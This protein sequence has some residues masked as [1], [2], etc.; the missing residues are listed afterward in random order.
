LKLMGTAVEVDEAVNGIEGGG[1][2]D[3]LSRE[4]V[5]WKAAPREAAV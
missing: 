1:G 4:A 2:D 3:A 5:V